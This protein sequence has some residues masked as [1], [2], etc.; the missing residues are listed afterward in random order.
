MTEESQHHYVVLV[1]CPE[2]RF[3]EDPEG[4][5]GG[6]ASVVDG[7]PTTLQEAIKLGLKEVRKYA[8]HDVGH[9][10]E[11]EVRDGAENDEV[12]FCSE[13][14][15]EHVIKSGKILDCDAILEK[16]AYRLEWEGE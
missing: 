15:R 2:C 10:I 4:C 9:P 5:F 6:K 11:F 13:F 16:R 8:P 7:E 14:D 12:V 3:D 1:Y